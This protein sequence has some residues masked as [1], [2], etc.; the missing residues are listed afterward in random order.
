MELSAHSLRVLSASSFADSAFIDVPALFAEVRLLGQ[1]SE[2]VV[3]ENCLALDDDEHASSHAPQLAQVSLRLQK[4]AVDKL[5]HFPIDL[6]TFL[7]RK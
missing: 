5:G 2:I 7:S 6:T 1:G 3:A 4:V